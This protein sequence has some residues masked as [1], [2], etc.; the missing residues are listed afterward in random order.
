MT[1]SLLLSIL[2]NKNFVCEFQLLSDF[3]IYL[4]CDP[5]LPD[6]GTCCQPDNKCGEG[7]GDCDYDEDCTED[8]VCGN[9]N[10]RKWN[11]SAPD[12]LDCCQKRISTK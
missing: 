1:R 10:C 6:Q 9:N 12:T 5:G 3:Q 4:G 2:K 11:P 8:L 7:E